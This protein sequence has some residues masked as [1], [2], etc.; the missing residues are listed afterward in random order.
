[1]QFTTINDIAVVINNT[2]DFK[3]SKTT[4]TTATGLD[5][6]PAAVSNTQAATT[7]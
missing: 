4:T 7:T 1:M 2:M 5:S 6:T 3:A